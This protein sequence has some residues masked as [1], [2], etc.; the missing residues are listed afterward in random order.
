MI[1]LNGTDTNTYPAL[2]TYI[3]AAG[4]QPADLYIVTATNS[5]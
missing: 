4:R 5:A 1:M 3:E 2:K